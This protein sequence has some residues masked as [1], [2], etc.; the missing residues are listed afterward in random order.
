MTRHLL[1]SVLINALGKLFRIASRGKQATK[2]LNNLL[3]I[4]IQFVKINENFVGNISKRSA[5]SSFSNPNCNQLMLKE[6]HHGGLMMLAFFFP[7]SSF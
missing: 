2:F 1:L 4:F 5:T 6:I 7:S 3:N